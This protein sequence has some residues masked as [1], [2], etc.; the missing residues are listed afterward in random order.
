M[1]D[2]ALKQIAKDV[3]AIKAAL[4]AG[5]AAFAAALGVQV[6]SG[7]GAGPKGGEVASDAD[8]DS[9]YG[10]PEIRRDPTAKYWSGPSYA[11][12]HLSA[13]P[14]D[15]LDAFAKYKDACAW[16]NE[17]DGSDKK[18]KYA[19]YDRRD[20]ARARGWAARMRAGWKPKSN[21]GDG[22]GFGGKPVTDED[23]DDGFGGADDDIPFIAN[24]TVYG[25][26]DR[27]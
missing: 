14:P 16:G 3:A 27:P 17:K 12:L 6:S 2:E 26:W 4:G 10:D 20:A 19:E 25:R 7:G 5:A 13:C 15:Y 9:S 18:K 22:G 21:G 8:L 24:A 1:S 11:G 23:Y